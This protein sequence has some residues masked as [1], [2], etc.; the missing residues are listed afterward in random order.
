M[1]LTPLATGPGL[2]GPD[3]ARELLRTELDR[4]EYRPSLLERLRT[5]LADLFDAIFGGLG[6]ASLPT[7]WILLI[8]VGLGA[9]LVALVVWVVLRT[10]RKRGTVEDDGVFGGRRRSAAGHRAAAELALAEGRHDD[11]VVEAVRALAA[12]LIERALLPDAPDLT[13]H[14]L[15]LTAGARFP[16]ERDALRRTGRAF[17]EVRYGDRHVDAPTAEA[18]VALERRISAARPGDAEAGPVAAV[19]R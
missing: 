7:W 17:D 2:P 11:A 14:E 16:G 12:G 3:D 8:L 4:P 10:R 13:V 18:A 1:R 15:T 19:P 5:W 6:G 9:A